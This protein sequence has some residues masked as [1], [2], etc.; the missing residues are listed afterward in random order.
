MKSKKSKLVVYDF[1]RFVKHKKTPTR[2]YLR[3]FHICGVTLNL[4]SR[5]NQITKNPV[6]HNHENDAKA[7]ESEQFRQK[8]LQLI[9]T[10]PTQV[11]KNVYNSEMEKKPSP[12]DA[13]IPIC[14]ICYVTIPVEKDSRKFR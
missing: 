2:V 4:N 8:L 10:G 7:I 6:M 1:Y 5:M 12:I 14:E 11:L 13:R 9:K 3:C